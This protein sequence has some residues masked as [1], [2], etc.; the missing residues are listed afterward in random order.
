MSLNSSICLI[1]SHGL[2]ALKREHGL[3]EEDVTQEV[4][5]VTCVCVLVIDRMRLMFVLML[6]EYQLLYLNSCFQY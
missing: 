3:V 6:F 1:T 2:L 5:S 4:N